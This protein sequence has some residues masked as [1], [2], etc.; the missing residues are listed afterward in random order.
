LVFRFWRRFFSGRR[1]FKKPV[2]PPVTGPNMTNL[3]VG[4]DVGTSSVRC[5]IFDEVGT[6]L[7]VASH[8]I[9][10]WNP[11]PEYYEQSSADI[12][13]VRICFF[14]YLKCQKMS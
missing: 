13:H 12:W 5:G 1:T 7:A 14:C 4:F 9:Q 11:E 3:F 6:R 8:P 10:T 2:L